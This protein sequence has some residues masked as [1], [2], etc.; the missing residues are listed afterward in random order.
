MNSDRQQNF[1]V[2]FIT[3]SGQVISKLAGTVQ[4]GKNI[5][6]LNPAKAL[7]IGQLYLLFTG[8]NFVQTVPVQIK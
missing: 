7:P 6:S 2:Q 4:K 5:I 8:E 1:T 3:A